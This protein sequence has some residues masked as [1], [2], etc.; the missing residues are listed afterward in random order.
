MMG[1]DEIK[2]IATLIPVIVKAVTTLVDWV[3][4]FI[5][6]RRVRNKQAEENDSS[7]HRNDKTDSRAETLL[8]SE[9]SIGKLSKINETVKDDGENSCNDAD[10]RKVSGKRRRN[11]RR[12]RKVANSE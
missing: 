8:R 4:K 6:A 1:A 9:G 11:Q 12:H 10:N 2:A 5:D 3:V 7:T